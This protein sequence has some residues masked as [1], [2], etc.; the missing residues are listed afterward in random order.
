MLEIILIVLNS[1]KTINQSISQ[2]G[3]NCFCGLQCR[4]MESWFPVE[5]LYN[6]IESNIRISP[7]SVSTEAPAESQEFETVCVDSPKKK[8]KKAHV[9]GTH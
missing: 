4:C 8:K 5:N 3:Q 6:F 9:V 2:D 1:R 7:A